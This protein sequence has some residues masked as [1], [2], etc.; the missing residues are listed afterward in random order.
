MSNVYTP[1]DDILAMNSAGGAFIKPIKLLQQKYPLLKNLPLVECNKTDSHEYASDFSLPDPVYRVYNEGI[2]ATDGRSSVDEEKTTMLS[3]RMA[4][5]EDM[6]ETNGHSMEYLEQK[7]YQHIEAIYQEIERAIFYN[8]IAANPSRFNGLAVRY[9]TLN[10]QVSKQI[11]VHDG[12]GSETGSDQTSIWLLV[13]GRDSIAMLYPKGTPAGLRRKEIPGPTLVTD[14]GGSKQFRGVVVDW[15]WKFGL[16]LQDWRQAARVCNID[17]GD[18]LATDYDIVPW[19]TKAIH[20]IENLKAGGAG[21]WM[22]RD[23][24]ELLDLQCQNNSKTVALEK[25]VEEGV[26]RTSLRG[27]PIHVTDGISITEDVVA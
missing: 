10:S 8:T 20:R 17:M 4:I 21:F 22:N 23:T 27:I 14:S 6:L 5:D 9:G 2:E 18:T 26:M 16:L 25:Y 13:P 12:A 3:D 15:L 19:M 7:A 1:I 24:M 11:L